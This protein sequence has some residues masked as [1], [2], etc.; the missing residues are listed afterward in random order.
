[1][2][3]KRKNIFIIFA[4]ANVFYLLTYGI[5]IRPIFTVPSSDK[6]CLFLI[7]C[8]TWVSLSSS[9]EAERRVA[10]CTV[11]KGE[12]RPVFSLL[13][14]APSCNDNWIWRDS[15]HHNI[16][17]TFI[18]WYFGFTTAHFQPLS[19]PR[20]KKIS[21]FFTKN[22]LLLIKYIFTLKSKV[23]CGRSIYSAGWETMK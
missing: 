22:K 19:H 11:Y 12:P 23:T 9:C 18:Q 8:I 2:S 21:L 17:W 20:V 10:L 16:K 5:R 13:N 7:K 6:I 4:Q 15:K 14:S 1:M 3:H